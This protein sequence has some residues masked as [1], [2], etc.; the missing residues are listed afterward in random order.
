M[1][2]NSQA[3]SKDS[4]A[5]LAALVGDKWFPPILRQLEEFEDLTLPLLPEECREVTTAESPEWIFRCI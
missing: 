5:D 2:E 4:P 1:K 3:T